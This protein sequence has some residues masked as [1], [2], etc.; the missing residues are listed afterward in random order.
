MEIKRILYSI[1]GT[2]D[3][4]GGYFDYSTKRELKRNITKCILDRIIDKKEE[5]SI[6][7]D[8]LEIKLTR[9]NKIN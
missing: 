5:L 8:D 6:L 9:G 1:S 2:E 3:T 7:Y 4:D